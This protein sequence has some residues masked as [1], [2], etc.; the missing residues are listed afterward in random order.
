M[1]KIMM[2]MLCASV[3]S[4]PVFADSSAN[5]N[6]NSREVKS[7]LNGVANKVFSEKDAP[8]LTI[9]SFNIAAGKVSS[10]Q[11]IAHAIKAMDADI[12]ALQEVDKLTA[13]SGKV[14]Q[15]KEIEKITGMQ[16]VFCRA[17]DFDGGEYGLSIL[18]K[19]PVTLD[20]IIQLPSGQREQRIGCIGNVDVPN[21]AAPITV[22]NT[23]LDTKE[24]PQVRLEQIRELN[25]RTMEM[26]GI[27]IL[28][29]D[30]NDVYS[31]PNMT[32]V[33][34]YWNPV[35]PF[36]NDHRTWPSVNPEIGVDYIF[37]SNAQRWDIEELKV[38]QGMEVWSGVNWA[39][40]SDHLPIFTKLTLLEQ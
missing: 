9:A 21:F 30:M 39:E 34:K 25:D 22:I 5:S 23:H 1:N 28:L 33:T 17:I 11:D 12:V 40:V 35:T 10:A 15:L 31:T 3:I 19:Y 6:K 13:R 20:E 36:N 26:R 27:K 14:D 8:E 29:G 16:G 4:A 7:A 24:N 2:A 18:S 37:T 38:P 32:E